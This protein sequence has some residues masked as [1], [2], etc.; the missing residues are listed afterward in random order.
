MAGVAQETLGVPIAAVRFE[1]GDS[2][3]PPAAVSGGSS[4]V[5]SVAPAVP[6]AC[7][8]AH[9]ELFQMTCSN[10][11]LGWRDL[12]VENAARRKWPSDRSQWPQ[13]HR[14]VDPAERPGLDG[15]R[16][17]NAEA[18]HSQLIGGITFGI[19]MALL[20]KTAVDRRIGRIVN[21]NVAEYLLPVNAD[22]PDIRAI[23]VPNDERTSHPLGTKG[24]G[25]LPM[26]G[27]AAAIANAVYRAT[28][29]RVRKVPICIEDALT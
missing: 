3:F 17:L 12:P 23:L 27:A 4:A 6:A 7:E 26:V 25:E 21:A 20:E 10:S 11:R 19:G 9:T 1:L 5:P 8:A 13:L 22:V 29:K 14:G 15:G 18:A 24:I 16:V 2:S 28:G